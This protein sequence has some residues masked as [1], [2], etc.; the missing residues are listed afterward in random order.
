MKVKQG[1]APV[2]LY[3]RIGISRIHVAL[4]R[5]SRVVALPIVL[6]ALVPL[7]SGC[8]K[9]VDRMPGFG[10]AAVSA[11]SFPVRTAISGVTLPSASDGDG[12][13]SYALE[14]VPPGLSFD[15]TNRV[16][17]G[18]PIAVGVYDVTYGAADQDGDTA[19]LS[20]TIA[21]H[22]GTIIWTDVEASKIVH[23]N[24]DGSG[25]VDLVTR[26]LVEPHGVTVDGTNGKMYWT[27][28]S[29]GK[30][31][32]ANLD[33]TGV[34]DLA[35]ELGC[36]RG[37]VL[38]AAAGKLYWTE[39]GWRGADIRRA[40]LD[41]TSVEILIVSGD[42]GERDIALDTVEGKMYWSDNPSGSIR[43]ASLDGSGEEELVTGLSGPRGIAVDVTG[44][45]IYWADEG[46]AGHRIRR[47]NLDGTEVTDL[48]T[49]G[50]SST[51]EIELDVPGGKMY[52]ADHGTS[53]VQRSNLNGSGVEDLV[54]A[55]M[56]DVYG[57]P[58]GIALY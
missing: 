29:S 27:D 51:T 55:G 10:G 13:L 30:I 58:Y 20:F 43:C 16:L 57:G 42:H 54:T 24:P 39:D 41:G 11:M 44:G 56:E 32:R 25:V 15:A 4:E 21:I 1:S 38:D 40:N 37:I 3:F 22:Y 31:Q 5:I 8:S 9:A 28:C 7:F 46:G 18:T 2:R 17:S 6:V 50:L 53:R 33:G 26:G 14:P 23:A 52:W 12:A 34:E 49:S 48:V 45:R 19:S 35:T 47:S 36:P